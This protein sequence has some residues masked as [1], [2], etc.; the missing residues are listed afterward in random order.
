MRTL[1]WFIGLILIALGAMAAFTYPVWLALHARFGFPFHRIADR[2]GLVA[3]V[4]GFVVVARRLALADRASLGYGAPRAVFLREV[5]IGFAIG[6][7][8]MGLVVAVMVALGLREWKSGVALGA[9]HLLALAWIGLA[10]GFAVALIEETLLRGAMYTGIAREAGARV[11]VIVTGLI[12]AATHFV[13]SYHIPASQT[14]WGS[15]LTMLAGALNDFTH[16]LA[17]GDAYLSLFAVGVALGMV[18]ALTGH[19]GGCIGLHASWVWVITFVRE[20][21]VP[22]RANPLSFLLSNFDGVVGWLVLAWTLVLGI[23]LFRFYSRRSLI[24]PPA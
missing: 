7:P 8:M 3:V 13:A 14:S 17:I 4:I 21:S 9:T 16:P 15:G 6:A 22:N 24:P 12:Y 11:A 23:A 20:T 18:R 5:A 10:R 2:I 1:A 19:I